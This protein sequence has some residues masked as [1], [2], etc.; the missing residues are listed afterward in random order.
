MSTNF[1][2]GFTKIVISISASITSLFSI[3]FLMLKKGTLTSTKKNGMMETKIPERMDERG[4]IYK[5]P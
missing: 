2:V 5:V 4:S 1:I 3:Q